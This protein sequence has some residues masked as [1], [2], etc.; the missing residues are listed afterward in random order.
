M[1]Y[2]YNNG[3]QNLFILTYL[4]ASKPMMD[5]LS[6]Y[7]HAIISFTRFDLQLASLLQVYKFL[8][9]YCNKLRFFKRIL[10][11]INGFY[12]VQQIKILFK[13]F[14]FLLKLHPN[15]QKKGTI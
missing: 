4:Q 11:E 1:V 7:P 9:V 6:P 10:Q 8:T 13:N 2:V 15:I 12:F 5:G 14:Y 3:L